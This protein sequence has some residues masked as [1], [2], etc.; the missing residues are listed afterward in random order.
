MRGDMRGCV[1]RRHE[2]GCVGIYSHLGRFR[3]EDGK[4]PRQSVPQSPLGTLDRLAIVH[5]A[6]T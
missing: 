2:R 3:R 6:M 4:C 1:D 5:D